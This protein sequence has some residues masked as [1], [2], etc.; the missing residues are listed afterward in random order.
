[1]KMKD[2]SIRESM[3]TGVKDLGSA[4]YAIGVGTGIIMVN[5]PNSMANAVEH[6]IVDPVFIAGARAV[7]KVGSK[8]NNV[9]AR[10]KGK[11]EAKENEKYAGAEV[12]VVDFTKTSAAVL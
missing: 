12:I 8:A 7:D 1:M 3:K 4:A 5:V 10:I 11:K 2:Y 6:L 9:K